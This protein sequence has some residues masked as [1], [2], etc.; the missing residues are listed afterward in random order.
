[1]LVWLPVLFWR[2]NFSQMSGNFVPSPCVLP[3]RLIIFSCPDCFHL[4]PISCLL[5]PVCT[6]VLCQ[7]ASVCRTTLRSFGNSGF[8]F[9]HWDFVLIYFCILHLTYSFFSKTLACSTSVIKSLM[10]SPKAWVW[11]FLLC[12]CHHDSQWVLDLTRQLD[13]C[14]QCVDSD[15]IY[16]CI[17]I[18][19]Y[20][21]TYIH[22]YVHAYIHVYIH[23]YT[24]VHTQIHKLFFMLIFDTESGI[25]KEPKHSQAMF[26]AV[27]VAV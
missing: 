23:A 10:P 16:I 2:L 21:H 8:V 26:L 15:S 20:I 4:F 11:S 7:F 22:M 13:A 6:P 18:C 25:N 17:N 24:V 1:M 27:C 3:N 12:G 9:L 5:Y 14:M 19:I